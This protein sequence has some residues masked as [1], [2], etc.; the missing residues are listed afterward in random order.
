MDLYQLVFFCLHP[1]LCRINFGPLFG[2][3]R[4]VDGIIN[5]VEWGMTCRCKRAAACTG[6]QTANLEDQLWYWRS[7]PLSLHFKACSGVKLFLWLSLHF[8][9]FPR[10]MVLG[11]NY[12][13]ISVLILV[14]LNESVIISI[15]DLGWV[16]SELYLLSHR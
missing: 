1:H 6:T 4:T 8:K 5:K 12:I 11:L 13:Y 7:M 2:E 9:V 16:T 3:N 14:G 15:W 10:T